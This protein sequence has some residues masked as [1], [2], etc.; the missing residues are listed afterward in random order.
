MHRCDIT[1]FNNIH[2][3]IPSMVLGQ[4]QGDDLASWFVPVPMEVNRHDTIS[5]LLSC[6]TENCTASAQ[7]NENHLTSHWKM[8]NIS[9]ERLF[10]AKLR[11]ALHFVRT[12]CIHICI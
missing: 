1:S 12:L 8:F 9:F 7:L 10:A 5:M 6:C 4:V 3:Y 2:K 11:I